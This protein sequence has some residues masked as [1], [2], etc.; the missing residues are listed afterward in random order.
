MLAL[1]QEKGGE[2]AALLR[3]DGT[4]QAAWPNR[5]GHAT[6]QNGGNGASFARGRPPQFPRQKRHSPVPRERCLRVCITGAAFQRRAWFR[7]AH[8]DAE[9]IRADSAEAESAQERSSWPFVL[10]PKVYLFRYVLGSIVT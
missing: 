2:S 10:E 6:R 8:R 4:D 5:D 9:R 7:I 1:T 3:S